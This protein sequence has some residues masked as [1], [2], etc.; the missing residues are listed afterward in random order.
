MH[1]LKSMF[2]SE[3]TLLSNNLVL[4]SYL[5]GIYLESRF[6]RLWGGV[7]KTPKKRRKQTEEKHWKVTRKK[8]EEYEENQITTIYIFGFKLYFAR[9]HNL[10]KSCLY[11]QILF[12][13]F[14]RC[15]YADIWK[16][17]TIHQIWIYI[18]IQII[19]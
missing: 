12:T 10:R 8:N 1:K 2:F 11:H 5:S 7:Q 19:I 17:L 18:N 14:M 16:T 13:V 9:K 6:L 15:R 4:M 3:L